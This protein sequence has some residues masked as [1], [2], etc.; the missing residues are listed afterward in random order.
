M[1]LPETNEAA[2]AWQTV[3]LIT[4]QTYYVIGVYRKMQETNPTT[5]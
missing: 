2:Q 1:I 3:T 5:H 4:D